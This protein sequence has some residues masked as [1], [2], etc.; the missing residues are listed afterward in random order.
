MFG[1]DLEKKREETSAKGPSLALSPRG[2]ARCLRLARLLLALALALAVTGTA[3]ADGGSSAVPGDTGP[4]IEALRT[5]ARVI[6]DTLIAVAAILMVVGVATGFVA[7]QLLTTLGAPY[8]ASTAMLRV[9]SVV[10]LAIGAFLT[11][12]IANAIIDA[13]AGMVPATEIRLPTPGGGESGYL[14]PLL[15]A[16]RVWAQAWLA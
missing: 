10:L 15:P 9:V 8:G 1:K 5:L 4:L 11:T 13:V 16:L 14:E 2:A 7:G 3:L 6:V 12:V